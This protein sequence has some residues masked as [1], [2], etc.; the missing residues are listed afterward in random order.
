LK[1]VLLLNNKIV[2]NS[3]NDYEYDAPSL[4]AAIG[5]AK[6]STAINDFQSQNETNYD[7]MSYLKIKFGGVALYRFYLETNGCRGQLI[8]MKQNIAASEAAAKKIRQRIERIHADY[9][10]ECFVDQR[11]RIRALEV[12][13]GDLIVENGKLNHDFDALKRG[14]WPDGS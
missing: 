6:F 7:E 14:Q 10:R 8:S 9:P 13:I 4:S 5:Q 3:E 12:E 2:S 1:D 11:R